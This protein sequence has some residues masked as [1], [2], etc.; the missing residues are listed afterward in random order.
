MKDRKETVSNLP[1]IKTTAE[2][3]SY[4][5]LIEMF[6]V[7]GYLY[8]VHWK[9]LAAGYSGLLLNILVALL[10]PWP[11]KLILDYVILQAPLPPEAAFITRW[12]GTDTGTL[13][14]TLVAAYIILYLSDSLASYIHKVGLLTAA[15]RITTD[16]RDRIFTHL[17]ELSLSF[18][19]SAQSGDLVYRM[20]SDTSQ[21][22]IVMVELPN[23]F[24]Y[25]AVTILSHFALMFF[26]EW[27]LAL[28]AC[29]VLPLLYY[30]NRRYGS[31][32]EK[33][34]EEMRHKESDVS[35]II[36][37]NVS[38]MAVIK[39]YGR[40]D[41][42]QAR[43]SSENRKSMESGIV[44]LRLSKL[45]RRLNDIL[46]AAGTSGVVIY[47]GILA[48]EGAIL[49][50]TLVLF[51]AYLKNLYKPVK[52][53]AD[54]ML[55]VVK[56]QVSCRR[57]LEIIRCNIIMDDHPD[58]APLPAVKGHIR[59][60]DVAF[61]YHHDLP[62]LKK[63]NFVVNPGETIA[64]VGHSGAGKS[65]L[66]SLLMRFYDPQSGQILIDGH[67]I[68]EVTIQSL[69]SQI[70]VLMQ[71]AKLFNKSVAENIRFGKIDATEEEI[72]KAAKLAQAHDF[73]SG[74]PAG[75]RT[76]VSEGGENLSGGQRQRINI[77]R[78]IIRNTP[79][80]IL[81]EPATALDAK[82]EHLIQAAL[83]E[84]TAVKTTFIIAHKFSTIANADKILVLNNGEVAGF[85]KHEALLDTCPSY[86]EFYELQFG[87]TAEEYSSAIHE[88]SGNGKP[89]VLKKESHTGGI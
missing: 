69:R 13:L 40:E 15:E 87:V 27:R 64:L 18:H 79:I 22:K 70:T 37:E 3:F 39:A 41:T 83:Q 53:F 50:G 54:M 4:K 47:G 88:V 10:L 56:A 11:L 42:Q 75:Y 16:I 44:A 28:I 12:L 57:L 43:F 80:L 34:T 77:A 84:L 35:A 49:P 55:D 8:K 86:R 73:I 24:I 25:R 63:V 33:A 71:E 78:A 36:I 67:D 45:F 81:D 5:T 6:K 19:Q 29:S 38:A 65:T 74:M 62:V 58:A 9:P 32:V 1:D 31:G 2:K 26:L 60:R 72:I 17:Q 76:K 51:V 85:G 61:G 68:R 30:Y 89:V 46:M 14:I 52:K 20:T 59:F 21:I 66:I 48:L 82:T 7:F 23:F